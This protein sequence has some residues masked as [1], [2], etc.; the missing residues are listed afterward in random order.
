MRFWDTSA[1][2][3][4]I[5]REPTTQRMLDLLRTDPDI[6]VSAVTPVE[7]L[8]ALARRSREN[9][10]DEA[11]KESRSL[12]QTLTEHW[13]EIA[14]DQAIIQIAS[15]LLFR[16]ILKAADALQL[17]TAMTA[18]RELP[19]VTLDET[20]AAAARQEGFRVEP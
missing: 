15:E 10:D 7:I 11:L 14:L 2:V 17:A 9:P 19:F 20:L 6:V 12:L 3:P 4:L 16:R 5:V 1:L 13:R 8:S 18:V